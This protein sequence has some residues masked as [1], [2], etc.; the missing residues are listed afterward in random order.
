MNIDAGPA[1]R[2]AIAAVPIV[3]A[4]LFLVYFIGDISRLDELQR[5]IHLEALGFA[6]PLTILMLMTLGLVQSAVALS[7]DDW[8]YR[9]IW[10]YP[11]IFYFL[12]LTIASH[13]YE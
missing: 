5:R 11:P 1:V 4:A 7:P 12:G 8:S 10:F 13:R 2:I 3:P 9:H 6:F